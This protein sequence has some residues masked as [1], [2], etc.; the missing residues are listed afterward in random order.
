MNNSDFS[1]AVISISKQQLATLPAAQFDGQIFVVETEEQLS[2][3]ISCL[4]KSD[5]I[6]FDTETRP[7]FRKGMQNHVSLV[8]LSTRE[9]CFL[10]RINL[11]GLAKSLIDILENPEILKIG[12]STHDDFHNL[13]KITSLAPQGFVDLQT[14]VKQFKIADNSLSRIYGIIFGKRIS[15]GQRLTNWEAETLTPSQ[16]GYAALDAMACIKIYDYLSAGRF[17]PK[18]SPYLIYPEDHQQSSEQMSSEQLPS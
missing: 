17:N 12:L 16:Q 1:K 11:T 6:G 10:F 5:I 7:S 2:D 15:K 8:Q 14:Y 3:A 18:S 9:V 4:R 13:N